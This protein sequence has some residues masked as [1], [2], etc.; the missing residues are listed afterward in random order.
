MGTFPNDRESD[1]TCCEITHWHKRPRGGSYVAECS[2]L[3]QSALRNKG[4][5][6]FLIIK[7]VKKNYVC[8]L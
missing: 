4:E 5:H 6:S 7:C 1:Q 8:I 3:K 2:R